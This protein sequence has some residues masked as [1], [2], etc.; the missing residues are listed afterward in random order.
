MSL[1]Q[2]QRIFW[3]IPLDLMLGYIPSFFVYQSFKWNKTNDSYE[4][5]ANKKY[6]G[7]Y[8]KNNYQKKILFFG[9][10]TGK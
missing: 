9:K 1:L 3:K 5:K 8:E 7:D 10:Q 2:E 6:N 4:K